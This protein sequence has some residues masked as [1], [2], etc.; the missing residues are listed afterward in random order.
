MYE[1]DVE[2]VPSKREKD[3]VLINNFAYQFNKNY[4]GKTYWRCRV[5]YKTKSED[6]KCPATCQTRNLKLISNVDTIEKWQPEK[7]HNHDPLTKAEI[8]NMIVRSSGK[9]RARAEPDT[10]ISDIYNQEINKAIENV[11]NIETLPSFNSKIIV[12]FYT[13]SFLLFLDTIYHYFF[14]PRL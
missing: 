11:E 7:P 2:T 13:K 3:M 9:K 14:K 5:F 6:E 12:W 8:I 10:K 1:L 4:N